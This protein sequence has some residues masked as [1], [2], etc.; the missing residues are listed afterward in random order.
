MHTRQLLTYARPYRAKLAGL[1]ALTTASS[2]ILLGIPWLAGR[3]FGGIVTG[4]TASHGTTVAVLV[5][6]L[7]AIAALNYATALQAASTSAGLLADLRYRVYQHV[8]HLPAAF[9]DLHSRGDTLAL[10]TVEISRL[11]AFLTGTLVT[12]PSRTLTTLGAIALMFT[13][14]AR[15]AWLVPILVPA[16]YLLLKTVGRRLRALA[17]QRQEAE[18]SAVAFA[19]ESLEML[20]ATKAFTRQAQQAHRYHRAIDRVLSLTLLEERI[21]AAMEPLITLLAAFGALTILWFAGLSLDTGR[22]TPAE[23]FSF[24]FYAALL[25][26]PVGALAHVY[27]QLQTAR[28]TLARLN[29]VLA[30][31]VEVSKSCSARPARASGD[32]RFK[33]VH[34]AYPGRNPI[35]KGADLHIRPGEIIGLTGPNGAGKTALINLLLRFY[36]PQSGAIHLDGRPVDDW[37]LE[38]LRRQIGLVPQS[39]YLFNGTIRENIGFGASNPNQEQIDAAA[40]LAQAYEFITTLPYG[41]NTLIGDRGLRLSGGQRQRIAL[42]R[43]LLKDPPILVFD[44]ATSMFDDEGE[45]AFIAACSEALI[46]RTVIFITHRPATLSLTD[47][48]LLLNDGRVSEL[49]SSPRRRRRVSA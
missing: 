27:G 10:M 12:I 3:L 13:I 46:G 4:E 37:N 39:T 26:R 8:Q 35:L 2:I 30:E 23:L 33:G 41:M 42:A 32:I 18:A 6:C 48:V 43:A 1:V 7:V 34:F 36:E 21:Y 11:S 14:D 24:L 49:H 9:H 45:S 29:D 15:L 44:E 17:R 47:R 5:L 19:E 40:R 20:P 31:P 25:T 22:M 38:D 16:F 28:G